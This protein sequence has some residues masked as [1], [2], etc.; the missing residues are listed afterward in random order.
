MNKK[1]N[2]FEEIGGIQN[3]VKDSSLDA[4]IARIKNSVRDKLDFSDT[5]RKINI[6]KS[7]KKFAVIAAAAVLVLGITVFA[8]GGL[9]TSWHSSSSSEAEYTSLPTQEQCINDVGYAP[10]LKDTFENEYKFSEGSVVKNDLRDDSGK[11]VE[12][13]N[14]LSLRYKKGDDNVYMSVDKYDSETEDYGDIIG[15]FDGI[16]IYYY[17][18]MNK[19]VPP[20][21]EMTEEDKRAEESG[22]LVFSCGSSEVDVS[23]VQSVHW[24]QNGIRYSLM[25]IGGKLSADEMT[26]MAKELIAK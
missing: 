10:V 19:I 24:E 21:Y 17:S 4:D 15:S 16:D 12:K 18:Y 6:M 9:V 1:R 26:E 13:F 3:D 14:S 8:A 5:E 11:S 22:E 25:Q 7:K 2:L 20:D 23:K